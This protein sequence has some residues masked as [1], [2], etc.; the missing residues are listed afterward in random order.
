MKKRNLFQL[1]KLNKKAV[2]LMVGY[3]L[4]I[5]LAIGLSIGVFFYLKLYLPSEKPKCPENVAISIDEVTCVIS[6][7][8]STVTIDLTNRGFF[9]IDSAFIK[10]GDVDRVFKTTLNK[11]DVDN[12]LLSSCGDGEIGLKPNEK[13]CD[14]FVYSE[15]PIIEQEVTVEPLLYIDD[16][17]VLCSEKIAKKRITCT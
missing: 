11:D 6:G 17:P 13:F 8:S 1:N 9:K 7:S 2:S 15:S 4:L 3:V 12:R 16:E 14:N 10:I 5:A